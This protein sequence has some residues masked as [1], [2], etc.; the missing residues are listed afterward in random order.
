MEFEKWH[1]IGN[2]FILIA[3]PDDQLKL[4]PQQVA[5]LCDRRFGIGA[6]GVIR[7]ASG[8]DGSELFMDYL[9]SDGSVGEMC[10]NGIRCLA[11]FARAKGLTSSDE[12]KVGT[13]AGIKVVSIEGQR[14][15]VDMGA[16]IFDAAS[17]PVRAEDPLH[18]DLATST[19]TIEASCLGMGNPHTVIFVDDP[20]RA[21]VTTLGPEIEH[22]EQFPNGTNVEWVKVESADHVRMT[23][24]ERGS[25]ATMAC[26]TGAVAAAV[27]SRVLADTQPVVTV[28]LPGGDLQVEW[29]GSRDRETSAF[30][31]GPAVRSFAGEVDLSQYA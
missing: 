28:S 2:D 6:D 26:G 7:A 3:D 16:P 29:Q 20:T 18:V 25:G 4:S 9:N 24:W 22:M 23:V 10:G 17:I 30:L 31:T 27:A 14:V 21:P 5:G 12:I 19:G 13:R 15:R 1:G 11:L 8:T